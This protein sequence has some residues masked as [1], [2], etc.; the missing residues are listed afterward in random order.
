MRDPGERPKPGVLRRAAAGAWHVPAA[1]VYLLRRPRLWPL[2]ALP[3]LLAAAGLAGGFVAGLLAVPWA[4]E[5]VDP[6]RHARGPA[7]LLAVAAL[8]FATPLACA[9]IGL[10]LALLLA[11]PLLERL[12][13]AVEGLERGATADAAGGWRETIGAL[14]GALHFALRAPLALAASFVPFAG[15]L[16]SGLWAAHALAFQHTDAP[17]ARLGLDFEERRLFHAEHRAET[18][19]FGVAALAALLVPVANLLL[20]P[21][22]TVGATRLVLELIAFDHES[23]PEPDAP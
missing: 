20:A 13:R 19:G 18:L 8:W 10:A 6:E 12:S 16:I 2:A 3:A 4:D 11:A 23:D 17:L 22:L 14:R 1:L 9:L 15:P 7:A 5:L 21:A